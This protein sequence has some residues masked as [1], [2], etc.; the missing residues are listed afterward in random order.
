MYIIIYYGRLTGSIDRVHRS[1]SPMTFK[2]RNNSQR[3]KAENKTNFL[4]KGFIWKKAQLY[5]TKEFAFVKFFLTEQKRES[6]RAQ[7]HP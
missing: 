5:L 6:C 1:V 2:A 7:L 3:K 4:T